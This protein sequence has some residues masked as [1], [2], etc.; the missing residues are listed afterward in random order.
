MKEA[1]LCAA[2]TMYYNVPMSYEL[3]IYIL[4][5]VFGLF[6]GSFLNLVSDRVVKKQKIVFDRSKCDFCGRTLKLKNLVPLFSFIFQGGKCSECKGKLSFFYP[7]S[8]VMTGLSF[9]VAGIQSK[10]VTEFDIISVLLFLYMAG[11][12]SFLI[13]L[14]LTDSK[15][16][17][18]PD[19]IVYAGIFYVLIMII[20]VYAVDLFMYYRQLSSDTIGKYLI[21]AGFWNQ[22]VIG[23]LKSLIFLLGSSF[24]ISLFF[25]LLIW[26]TKGRGMGGG[27]VKLGFLI[28]LFNGL[29]YNFLAIFL[30]FVIGAVYSLVLIL[31]RK[32]SLKD[33]IAFGPFLIL[34]A[35]I[36]FLWGQYI[37]DW[38]TGVLK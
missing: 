13:I 11:A 25:F 14:F 33:T 2:S 31:L 5:F 35:V 15:Y 23:Y 22:A 8:E 10:L 37:V 9:V 18:I 30:G 34:G 19:K 4:L 36:A 24:V 38:Y 21:E 26:I 7:M 29:P 1:A 16:Q 17:L 12:L 6:F 3:Y 20:S 32:K 27:D 28:G